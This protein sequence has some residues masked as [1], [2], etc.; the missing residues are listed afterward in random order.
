MVTDFQTKL[1]ADQREASGLEWLRQA[2]DGALH[3]IAGVKASQWH[4]RTPCEDMDVLALVEHMT[5]SLVEL[6]QVGAN[7][8][9]VP[10]E[11]G[12]LSAEAA[13]DEYHDAAASMMSA[14]SAPDALALDYDMPW[15]VTPGTALV[16]FMVIEH[17]AHGWDLMKASGQPNPFA[18]EL[19]RA[20]LH[21]A[22][23]YDSPTI[24]VPGMFG[25]EVLAPDDASDIERLAAFLGRRP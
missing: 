7:K 5:E 1:M 12:W 4:D 9:V 10:N 25:P 13:A 24:R 6:E 14:W 15:G 19:V 17:V 3:L 11:D 22:R 2:T 23:Q 8:S 16:D 21:G 20:A 18:N